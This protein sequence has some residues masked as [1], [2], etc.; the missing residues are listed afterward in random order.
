MTFFRL[1]PRALMTLS[2]RRGLIGAALRHL[3]DHLAGQVFAGERV[4]V[5]HD[6]VGRALRDDLAAMDA[7]AGAD[8][9]HMIGDADRVLVV[10]HHDHGVAEVAQALERFEQARIVALV[11]ADRGLVEHVEHAGQPR[12]DLRGEA[13]ALALAARERAGGARQREV[14]EADVDQEAQP[15]ADFLQDARR[16]LVL[17]LVEQLRQRLEP[18]AGALDRHLG[19]FADVQPADLHAQRLGLEPIA[20]AGV[21]RHVGEIFRDLLARPLALGFLPAALQVGDHAL[22][23]LVRLVGAH[24]VVVGEA[25]LVLARAVR[26]ASCARLRQVLPFG[27][28]RELV[29]LA[30]RLQGLRVVGAR[31]LRPGQRSR[32][33]AACGSCPG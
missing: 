9:E 15:L 28:E 5:R 31:R 12:A 13:D 19:D 30:E 8:V 33:L 1:L 24:A 11:Q 17:L 10:L 3:D 22:E 4:R 18:F 14:F 26:I 23:R 29:E 32:R 25:D 21:A 7:G 27:V 2:V 6:V 16:D 20:V